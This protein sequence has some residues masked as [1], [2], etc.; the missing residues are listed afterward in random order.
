M[1][2]PGFNVKSLPSG[3]L[4]IGI[5]LDT[6]NNSAKNFTSENGWVNITIT[7]NDEPRQ[8]YTHR[9]KFSTPKKSHTEKLSES[10][11]KKEEKW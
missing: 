10:L 3:D 2:K 9:G 11:E 8:G 1:D 4:S 7:K 6:F 5:H